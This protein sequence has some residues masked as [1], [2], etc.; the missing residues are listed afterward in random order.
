MY[1]QNSRENALQRLESRLIQE[2]GNR[3]VAVANL[4][5]QMKE[6]ATQLQALMDYNTKSKYL[7]QSIEKNSNDS[8]GEIS[9]IQ[10][11]I[12]TQVKRLRDDLDKTNG[13]LRDQGKKFDA[14][15]DQ[16]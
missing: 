10:N 9:K 4:D 6:T 1:D 7:F 8:N 16:L 3:T 15:C 13:H 12:A 14:L 11:E 5:F 2:E